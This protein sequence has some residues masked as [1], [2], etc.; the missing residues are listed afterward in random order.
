MR[1]PTQAVF[2]EGVSPF[3]LKTEIVS[4]RNSLVFFILAL[5]VLKS[6]ENL[7]VSYVKTT[8]QYK[9]KLHTEFS[10]LGFPHK[11]EVVRKCSRVSFQLETTC[12]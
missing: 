8:E 3:L 9:K 5:A 7:G 11:E 4:H 12:L 1:S 10:G 6:V 2:S